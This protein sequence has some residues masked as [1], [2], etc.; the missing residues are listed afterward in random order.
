VQV[1]V[2]A[3]STKVI[4]ALGVTPTEPEHGP[5]T[6]S[7]AREG[8]LTFLDN[9]VQDGTG[10]IRLRATVPNPDFYFW[11]GQYV[12]VRVILT[13]K[14]NAVLVPTKSI[15]ISQQGPFVYVAKA[16]EKNPQEQ[17]AELRPVVQ[18]QRQGELVVVDQAVKPGEQVIVTG[19]ALIAPG[20]PVKITNSPEAPSSGGNS[21]Q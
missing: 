2:P 15:Q 6:R 9:S 13:I 12:N 3:D 14:E 11:P 1:E 19:Q 21:K 18:G 8:V 10:T 7:G 4:A 16:N 5:T 17:I 20:A